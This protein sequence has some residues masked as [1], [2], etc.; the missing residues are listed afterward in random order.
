VKTVIPCSMAK[1][2]HNIVFQSLLDDCKYGENLCH[3][4]SDTGHTPLHIASGLGYSEAVSI[5]LDHGA[6]ADA[7]NG[8]LE[9]PMHLAAGRGL[10]Q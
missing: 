6:S 5:L 4:T 3:A 7:Q 9:T 1:F 2:L 8:D 10:K